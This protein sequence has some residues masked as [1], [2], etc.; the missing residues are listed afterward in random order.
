[1]AADDMSDNDKF[2]A[3]HYVSVFHSQASFPLLLPKC[4]QVGV[5]SSKCGFVFSL[6]TSA[7]T[8]TIGCGYQLVVSRAASRL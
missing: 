6:K 2:S 3:L 8:F 1:M 7:R 4:A 5:Q